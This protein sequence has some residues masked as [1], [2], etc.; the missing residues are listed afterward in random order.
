MIPL[1]YRQAP[2]AAD[3][4]LAKHQ[5]TVERFAR[6]LAVRNTS[7]TTQRLYVRAVERWLT[8][9]GEPGHVDLERL[10][11]Y[12]AARRQRCAVATVNLDLKAL[13][14]FYRFQADW[15]EL[16]PAEIRKIPRGRSPP[17]RT[18]R[19]LAPH[20]VGEALATLPLDTFRGL[21]DY[22]LIRVAFECGL[23]AGEI[24]RLELGDILDDG[25]LFVRR[26]K[27]GV[28]RY[29]PMSE[30]L[31]G[32]L[33]GYMHARAALRPGR[34]VALWLREDAR[35][36]ASG[37]SV[38][39][40]VSRRLG[41]AAGIQ[42]L[43]RSGKP[44]QGLYPHQLRAGFATGMLR[45]GCPITAIAQLMGHASVETTAGYLGVDL[46]QLRAAARHH[47]RA[48]RAAERVE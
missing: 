26:G 6:G 41:R 18:P 35:P 19:L 10:A 28:D 42:H 12:L 34:K 17:A 29:V 20:Q 3:A 22:C 47:P 1:R 7:A 11:R 33:A 2:P 37:R 39:E 5:P 15:D 24:A 13:R 4:A 30:A 9:G 36:L 45:S 32:I 25:C 46:D 23:R 14:A 8:A 48:L 43:R 21:R 31:A 44:W 38:W 16:D 40:I 27:G